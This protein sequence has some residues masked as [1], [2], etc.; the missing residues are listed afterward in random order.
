MKKIF[1]LFVFLVFGLYSCS[2]NKPQSE[3]QSA[4]VANVQD[5]AK[6]DNMSSVVEIKDVENYF[7]TQR[8]KEQEFLV[9]ND[10]DFEKYFHPAKTMNNTVTKIDFTKE[11]VGAIILPE[12]EYN[13]TITIN[14]VSL[15]GKRLIV[16]Y[17]VTKDQNKQSYTI[18]PS[19]V[20]AFDLG[21]KVDSVTF[22]DGD[23]ETHVAVK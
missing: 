21:L 7:S 22:K 13:T 9:L 19:K 2:S 15:D 4:S 10:S 18:V 20:F 5:Q 12:T 6:A 3:Q 8:P 11:R 17:T 23:N 1:Y 14:K 16:D